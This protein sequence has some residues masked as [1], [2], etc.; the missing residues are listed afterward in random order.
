MSVQNQQ[1]MTGLFNQY[2]GQFNADGQC[3]LVSESLKESASVFYNVFGRQ[4][5]N[6]ASAQNP[7]PPAPRALPRSN[8]V[9]H[10]HYHNRSTF[11][12][13]YFWLWITAP[14]PRVYHRN[15]Y[16]G[17]SF[18]RLTG[19]VMQTAGS[20]VNRPARNTE[21]QEERA[22][23][24]V[25]MLFVAAFLADVAAAV[26]AAVVTNDAVQHARNAKGQETKFNRIGQDL[27]NLTRRNRTDSN[28]H[29]NLQNIAKNLK[30]I[31]HR[32]AVCSKIKAISVAFLATA[33][34]GAV[35]LLISAIARA[36]ISGTASLATSASGISALAFFSASFAPPCLIALATIASIGGLIY[37]TLQRYN[38]DAKDQINADRGLEHMGLLMSKV[39]NM[40]APSSYAEAF[41]DHRSFDN[42]SAPVLPPLPSAPPPRYL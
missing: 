2:F 3:Q 30:E 26:T 17:R 23:K 15:F 24:A 22:K 41:N 28:I 10:H 27:T 21:R 1:A 5:P 39:V 38:K 6:E 7:L 25:C 9:H 37:Y 16:V 31:G 33:S 29:A 19:H 11:D 42:A 34:V 14:Q 18:G 20:A 36:I 4:N 32:E 8:V 13:P 40:A 12:N 35:H